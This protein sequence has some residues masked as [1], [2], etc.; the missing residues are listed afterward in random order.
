MILMAF[1]SYLIGF[2]GFYCLF[3]KSAN[4]MD[5]AHSLGLKDNLQAARSL[6]NGQGTGL[7]FG[8][9]DVMHRSSP[10]SQSY[11]LVTSLVETG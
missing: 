1:A 8:K 4:D 2:H 9:P 3:F 7:G 10:T 6:L 11:C 5:C